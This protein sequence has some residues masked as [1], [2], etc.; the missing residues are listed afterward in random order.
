MK[1]KAKESRQ[2]I[3]AR[4]KLA[5]TLEFEHLQFTT[6]ALQEMSVKIKALSLRHKAKKIAAGRISQLSSKKINPKSKEI[7]KLMSNLQKGFESS[8]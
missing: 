6:E 1:G 2:V 8:I 4:K 7:Q 3:T 5:A